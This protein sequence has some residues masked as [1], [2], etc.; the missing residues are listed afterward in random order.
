MNENIWQITE[1]VKPTKHHQTCM[2]C[3]KE[4]EK[5]KPRIKLFSDVFCNRFIGYQ[6]Y[7]RECFIICLLNKFKGI[8]KPTK[9]GSKMIQSK[10]DELM[11]D[12][13]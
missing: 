5:G 8:I 2:F 4:L 3:N 10:L 1:D 9:K 7:H 13:L 12:E 11:V 6:Y